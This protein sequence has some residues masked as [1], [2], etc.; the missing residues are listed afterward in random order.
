MLQINTDIS[1]L[2]KLLLKIFIQMKSTNN[3]LF[4]LTALAIIILFVFVPNIPQSQSYHKFCDTSSIFGIANIYNVVSNIGFLLVGIYGLFKFHKLHS[5][6]LIFFIICIGFIATAFG[7]AYYHHNP[8]NFTLVFDRLPMTIVFASFFAFVYSLF[9]NKKYV[10]KIL[11]FTITLGVFSVLHWYYTETK[12]IG[13]LRLYALV[14]YLPML[15]IVVI[16]SLHYKKQKHLIP[17]ILNIGLWYF[18]AKIFE[19]FDNVFHNIFIVVGGH[20]LKHIAASAAAYFIVDIFLKNNLIQ[21]YNY[22][23]GSQIT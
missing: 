19:N 7:S 9:L 4:V 12:N 6:K 8:N 22:K 5:N 1:L 20:P 2:F 11:F 14:Q 23:Y 18:I 17:S 21:N 16:V 15:L 3:L 13:D 10:H